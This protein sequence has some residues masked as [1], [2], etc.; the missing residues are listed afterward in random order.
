MTNKL[1]FEGRFTRE[2][3]LKTVPSGNTV[4]NFSLANSKKFFDK[5]G[6]KKETSVFLNF[7]A[8]GKSAETI[9]KFC[10]KGGRL[11]VVA[12]AESKTTEDAEGKKTYRTEFTV[13]EFNIIDYKE[14]TTSAAD[15]YEGI[16]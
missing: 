15:S 12:R 5:N 2:P 7:T 13:E 8:W 3:E 10:G 16:L 11:T 9:A 4:C 1:F 6:E 14:T